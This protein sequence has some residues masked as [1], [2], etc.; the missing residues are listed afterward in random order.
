MSATSVHTALTA[1]PRRPPA[2][3]WTR[4]ALVGLQARHDAW[5]RREL[6]AAQSARAHRREVGGDFTIVP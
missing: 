3:S 2:F 6:D 1:K 4:R 5:I